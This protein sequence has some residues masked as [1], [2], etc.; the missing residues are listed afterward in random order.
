[1]TFG[2]LTEYMEKG[3]AHIRVLGRT[4]NYT[5]PDMMGEGITIMMTKKEEHV[6][7]ETMEDVE[8]AE[9]SYWVGEDDF[10]MAD[11]EG[12]EIGRAS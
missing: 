6:L 2:K 4:T 8:M 3:S 9:E 5:I 12:D 1:M 10:D 7:S 11:G